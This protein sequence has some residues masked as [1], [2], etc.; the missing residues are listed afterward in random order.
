MD[1]LIRAASLAPSRLRLSETRASLSMPA[2][3]EAARELI[4]ERR[5][6]ALREEIEAQLRAE[7]RLQWQAL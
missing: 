3:A 7:T 1:A 6:K 4:E 5:A 2:A